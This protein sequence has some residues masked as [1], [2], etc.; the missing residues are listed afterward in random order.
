[1]DENENAHKIWH[2]V[3]NQVIAEMGNII[4]IN[5]ESVFKF[6]E[7]FNLSQRATLDVIEKIKTLE[8]EVY[9]K[10]EEK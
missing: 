6:C 5:F 7:L 2:F 3:K 10:K 4:G 8:I 1:M 9:L